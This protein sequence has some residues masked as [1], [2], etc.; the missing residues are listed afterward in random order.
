MLRHRSLLA[1][2]VLA[3]GLVVATAAPAL[4]HASF[5]VRQVPAGESVSVTLRV[6]IETDARNAFVD[7]LVPEGWSLASCEGADGW[8]CESPRRN[9][10]SQVVNLAATGEG[11]GAVEQF[12]MTL[13]APSVQGVYSFPVVQTYDDESEVAWIGDPGTDRPAPRI[14]VG[15]D[16]TPVE[17]SSELPTHGE[18]DELQPRDDASDPAADAGAGD[19]P[20]GASPTP[21]PSGQDT[22]TDTDEPDTAEPEESMEPSTDDADQSSVEESP[23]DTDDDAT[24]GDGVDLLPWLL[25]A[26]VVLGLVAAVVVQRR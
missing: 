6:P 22:P 17:R 24:D 4:A 26:L 21:D 10:G 19:D 5:D 7:V 1:S 15:D 18:D 11:A 20:Q 23:S 8:D 13:V 12:A 2:I 25:G 16:T 14:Q 3:A 9:D